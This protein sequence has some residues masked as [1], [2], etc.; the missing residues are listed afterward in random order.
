MSILSF[1]K[2][3]KLIPTEEHNAYY[4]SDT[5]IAGTYVPNMSEADKKRW[6]GKRVGGK[7]PRVEIRKVLSGNDPGTGYHA[8]A[9]ILI[10]VRK[11][12]VVMSTNGRMVFQPQTWA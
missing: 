1:D 8:Y 6:K 11:S 7:D 4:K 2:P 9:Q 5:D 10:V 12:G 3:K